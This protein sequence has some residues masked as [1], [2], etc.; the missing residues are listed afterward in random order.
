L[1][2]LFPWGLFTLGI[3][4]IHLFELF[5][6]KIWIN[7]FVQELNVLVRELLAIKRDLY[8]DSVLS[9]SDLRS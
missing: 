7:G 3:L 1:S 2:L 6:S 5:L 8:S 9:F 4:F